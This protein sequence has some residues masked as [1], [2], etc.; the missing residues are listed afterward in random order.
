MPNEGRAVHEALELRKLAYA[1]ACEMRTDLSSTTDPDAR[2]RLV[3]AFR[4][5]VAAWDS[6]GDRLRVLRGKGLPKAMPEKAR[7]SKA[8]PSAPM[9]DDAP[10]P[11]PK[12]TPTTPETPTTN[13]PPQG[14]S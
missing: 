13:E 5:S 10:T 2:M 1:V 11:E 7:K 9:D 3:R 14:I 4:D 8:K 6:A 12:T